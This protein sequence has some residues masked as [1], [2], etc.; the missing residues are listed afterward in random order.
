[1]KEIAIL[2]PIAEGNIRFIHMHP[3]LG[4]VLNVFHNKIQRVSEISPSCTPS[5][6]RFYISFVLFY[7]PVWDTIK[8]SWYNSSICITN[9]NILDKLNTSIT[10]L[11]FVLTIISRE[12]LYLPTGRWKEFIKKGPR[13]WIA[14]IPDLGNR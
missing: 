4:S 9:T 12:C 6:V 7:V 14:H 13:G 5:G 8:S 2:V 1:M 10:L 11:A 3:C